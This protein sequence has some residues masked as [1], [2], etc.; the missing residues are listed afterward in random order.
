MRTVIN[1]I[2]R[3]ESCTAKMRDEI[4]LDYY[5]AKQMIAIMERATLASKGKTVQRQSWEQRTVH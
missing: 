2:E 1:A 3:R 5:K 4:E